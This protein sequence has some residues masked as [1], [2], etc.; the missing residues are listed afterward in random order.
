[1]DGYQLAAHLRQLPGGDG[2][3]LVAITGYG[4]ARDREASARAGF[5]GHL[6]KPVDLARLRQFL[7]AK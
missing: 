3:R 6:F 7:A 1:M 4:Q 2:I 5:S